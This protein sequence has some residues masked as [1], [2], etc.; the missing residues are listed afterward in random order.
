MKVFLPPCGD[1]SLRTCPADYNGT[2]DVFLP[3]CGDSSL[4]TPFLRGIHRPDM[5]STPL[6]GFLSE[7]RI[8]VDLQA[9]DEFL[10]PCGDSSLRTSDDPQ[11]GGNTSFYP[12]AGIPL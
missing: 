2:I 8:F 7:D 3:P 9:G 1:S 6:R 4:R 11:A 10:P 12:L 5:V